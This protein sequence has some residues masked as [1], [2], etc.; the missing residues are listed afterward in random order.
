MLPEIG[1]N[2]KKK[3]CG[4]LINSVCSTK[5]YNYHRNLHKIFYDKINEEIIL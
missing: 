2:K 4:K 5:G 3:S 1:G